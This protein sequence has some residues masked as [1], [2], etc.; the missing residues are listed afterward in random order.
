MDMPA[1]PDPSTWSIARFPNQGQRAEFLDQVRFWNRL[2]GLP[3]IEVVL[4]P[5][6][7]SVRYWC[8]DPRQHNILRLIDAFG[9]SV[10]RSGGRTATPPRPASVA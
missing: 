7:L 5:D 8:A 1:T 6:G 3:R 10:Y 9:G 4:P 2:E